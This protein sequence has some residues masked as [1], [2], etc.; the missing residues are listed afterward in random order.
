VLGPSEGGLGRQDPLPRFPVSGPNAYRS[1]VNVS[2]GD[3]FQDGFIMEEDL[4][5]I[6]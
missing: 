5:Q 4:E 3:A 1:G 2:F 6:L